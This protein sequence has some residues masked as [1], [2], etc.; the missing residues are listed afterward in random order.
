MGKRLTE[1][2]D[3]SFCFGKVLNVLKGRQKPSCTNEL[4]I[5]MIFVLCSQPWCRFLLYG[6]VLSRVIL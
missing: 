4:R 3:Q 1:K 6:I 5:S 2:K